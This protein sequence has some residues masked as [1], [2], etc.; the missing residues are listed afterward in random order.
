M[1]AAHENVKET[2]GGGRKGTVVT[3][4]FQMDLLSSEDLANR[5]LLFT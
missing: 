3:T 5:L 2:A 4:W 1:E